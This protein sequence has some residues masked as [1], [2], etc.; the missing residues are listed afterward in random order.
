[1]IATNDSRYGLSD[2]QIAQ[3]HE[4]GYLKFDALIHGE[5]LERHI[6]V[7]DKLVERAKTYSEEADGFTL[8][9]DADGK[10]IPGRLHKIQGV[11]VA[12]PRVLD[13]AKE[14]EILGKIVSLL[15]PDLDIF[16]T[17]FFPM[18]GDGSVSTA[19]HQDNYYFGEMVGGG[20]PEELVTCAIYLQDSSKENGCL[21]IVPYSHTAHEVVDHTPATGVMGHGHWTDINDDGAIDV[22]CPGG[23]VLLFSPYLLHGSHQNNSDR[24]RYSTAWHYIPGDAQLERFQRDAYSDRHIVRT[25]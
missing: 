4:Q 1:M 14:P 23:T 7:F 18:L 25:S 9:Y 6:A 15:E 10:V 2:E 8:E 17:K 20:K 11:C 5:R 19:W 24:S 3:Y 16:G 13:L 22:E 12:D 21:K